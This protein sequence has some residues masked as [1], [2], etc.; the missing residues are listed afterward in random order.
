MIE[1]RL[2]QMLTMVRCGDI[3]GE[4]AFKG[5]DLQKAL[6]LRWADETYRYFYLNELESR[7]R[8]LPI[9]ADL[10]GMVSDLQALVRSRALEQIETNLSNPNDSDSVTLVQELTGRIEQE[11]GEIAKSR[12]TE[13]ST[14][15]HDALWAIYLR[16]EIPMISA[17][18]I[19]VP[20]REQQRIG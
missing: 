11:I 20:I 17:E 12:A 13:Y 6:D 14:P 9:H 18:P 7:W 2:D 8:I 16:N 1:T 3:L 10:R 5:V 15:W 4:E 19:I